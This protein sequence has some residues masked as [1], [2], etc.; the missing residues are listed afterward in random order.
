MVFELKVERKSRR[1][2]LFLCIISDS[3][4]ELGARLRRKASRDALGGEGVGTNGAAGTEVRGG[5]SSEAGDT[6]VDTGA[7]TGGGRNVGSSR[8]LKKVSLTACCG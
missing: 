4:L 8:G 1:E 2:P 7:E 3:F 6:D 5:P